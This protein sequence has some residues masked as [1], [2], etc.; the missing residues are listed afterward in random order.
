MKKFFTIISCM[1]LCTLP[2]MAAKYLRGV[3]TL[4]DWVAVEE[5]VTYTLSGNVTSLPASDIYTR[6]QVRVPGGKWVE[7]EGED[8]TSYTP[9]LGQKGFMIRVLIT[10]KNHDGGLWSEE[11]EIK[12][13]ICH[14]PVVVPHLT[15]RTDNHTITVWNSKAT[16][17]YLIL[18]EYRNDLTED[19]WKHAHA[20]SE[21]KMVY[22]GTPYKMNYVYTRVK[23]TPTMLPS[24]AVAWQAIQLGEVVSLEGI[25]LTPL[26]DKK[27]GQ[28]YSNK[29]GFL[30]IDIDPVPENTT[31]FKGVR[32]DHFYVN[33]S[34]TQT[35]AR[36]Y[37]QN[38]TSTPLEADKYYKRVYLQVTESMNNVVVS[39]AHPNGT[40]VL[41]SEFTVHIGDIYNN[42]LLDRL[43][44][45]AQTTL[46]KGE[47]CYVPFTKT[48]SI[49]SINNI[50]TEASGTGTA[51][52][53]S[54][55][56]TKGM[57][58]N[59]QYASAG[60]YTYKMSQLGKELPDRFTVV[61]EAPVVVLPN[62]VSFETTSVEAFMGLPFTA[63]ELRN[64][65]HLPV[66]Y[67]SS[68]PEVATVDS[69]TGEV[70]F[71]A[72]GET[73]I[74]AD[75]DG[76]ESY[77]DGTVW[78]SLSI[79]KQPNQLSFET[80]TYTAILGDPFEQPVLNNPL[81]LPVTYY[82][83]IPEVATIDENGILTLVGAGTT[84]VGARYAGSD[85]I[86][87]G[88]ASYD[89]TV[90]EPGV[91]IVKKPCDL[92]FSEASAEAS[93]GVPFTPPT[94]SNPHN[95]PITWSTSN[96]NVATADPET[97]ELTFV[98]E[99]GLSI[100]A[101]T[102][103]N[104]E[105]EGGRAHYWL[106]ISKHD[107]D[108]SYGG[109]EEVTVT[110]GDDYQL[111]VLSNPFNLPV[112]FSYGNPAVATVDETG[113]V[114]IVGVGGTNITART[115]GNNGF[116]SGV[117]EYWLTVIKRHHG[118]SFSQ[119]EITFTAGDNVEWPVLENPNNLE[120]NY[121][122][123]NY[124]VAFV[125]ALSGVVTVVG[126]GEAE[127]IATAI[128][129]KFCEGGSAKYKM[130]VSKQKPVLSFAVEE[131]EATM[132]DTFKQPKLNNPLGLPVTYSSSAPKVA[133][134]DNTGKVKLISPGVTQITASFAGHNLMEPASASYVLSVKQK[135]DTGIDALELSD[136]VGT[137]DIYTADGKKIN[138][139]PVRKGM[140][141]VYPANGKQQ[142][143]K[144]RKLIV[145]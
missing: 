69:A 62:E 74:Y 145:R 38:N 80:T 7:M 6:W 61:V 120:V 85:A 75:V 131:A 45:P 82:T 121:E 65:H 95:L 88:D 68:N 132:G 37:K 128:G 115:D 21:G 119:E 89:L 78:Y 26:C 50:T 35:Y 125:D 108:L 124:E 139:K 24:V 48:P 53:I 96:A 10:A 112:E 141:I 20:A 18:T 129:N 116:N 22:P 76:G 11:R 4:P 8:G 123:T 33:G 118:L 23:E 64:P 83:T 29:N 81:G 31:T 49:A 117:A 107:A 51:P 103:G 30:C 52:V 5:P 100:Y 71:V 32:G 25:M 54:F 72:A 43:E 60:T 138:G 140:Y 134:V 39:A 126:S 98:N 90:R 102:E 142:G 137:F 91:V 104:D 46:T 79:S 40:D 127:I 110:I 47:Y 114:T 1:L 16:Q 130:T 56:P 19:D 3:V 86:E 144:G 106:Y 84:T 77:E 44:V 133:T 28:Y 99:G 111:P 109:V 105:Y 13:Q 58:I 55:H 14:E 2:V 36:F 59:A 70:T 92:A 12:K 143:K 73:N 41:R 66:T 34:P 101:D 113:K 9:T 27:E 135:I 122:C 15:A 93:F 42:V 57:C 17:E 67:T 94:L 136:L 97:G 87:G 63:P